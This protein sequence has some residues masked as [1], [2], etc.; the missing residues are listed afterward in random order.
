MIWAVGIAVLAWAWLLAGHGRFWRADQRLGDAPAPAAWPEVVAVIPARDE[1]A[2]IGPVIAAHAATAYPGR[3]SVVL[4]DDGS[5]DGTAEIAARAAGNSPRPVRIVPGG[6]LPTGWSGKLWALAQGIEAARETAPGARWLLLTDADIL[7][8]PGTLSRLVA[9]GE[10][11]GLALVSL[12]ARLDARGVWGRL[13]IPAFVF[14]FQKLYP[15]PRINDPASAVAGAAGGCV[16][17]RREALDAIGGIAAIRGALIDDCALART[18]KQG[19]PRRPVWLGL[20]SDEAVSLRDNRPL[21]SV[22]KM[23]ART[24]FVQLGRSWAA[25]AGC[26]VGMAVLYLACPVAA[27]AW[28]LHGDPALAALGA[29]GWGLSAAA[30]LP[31]ARLY[32]QPPAWALTLPLAGALYT[33]MTLDSARQDL[34]GRGGAWKGRTYPGGA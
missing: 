24:A 31:T 9:K 1:A 2:S 17:I 7:H 30:Y 12:M 32:G 8:A 25:L 15:F 5:T 16:L 34:M 3:F 21:R 19:P 33:A 10:A 26:V 6:S 4:V 22:W 14:F 23:V 20:A 13:L 27:L 29:V 28:P 11:Q 18:V